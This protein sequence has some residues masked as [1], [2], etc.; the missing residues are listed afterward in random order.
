MASMQ[1]LEGFYYF[2]QVVDHG[3]F[4]RAARALGIPK[5]RLSRHVMA[6]ETR[7]NVRLVNRSTR[8]FVVTELG[9]EVYRHATAMLA[10]AD[11]ALEAVEFARAEPRGTIK[12]SSPVA[13]A[14]S[15]LAVI[16][17]DFLA[18]LPAVQVQ[19]HVSNR[20]VDVVSEGFDV[21]LRV[22][23]HPSGEDGLVMRSFRE[24][25][26][27]LV[28]S[29]AY[30]GRAGEPG[31]PAELAAYDTLDYA[32]EFDHRPWEL[33]GPGGRSARAEHTPRVVCHDFVVLRA[34][35][36]A[37]LGVARLPESVVREDLR[38]GTLKRVLPGWNTPQGIVHV[39]FPSRRGLLPAVRA[40]IDFLAERLP[41]LM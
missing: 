40:F 22:R 18:K 25:D 13:L 38:S 41:A 4:A 32:G 19:L 28:A 2:T 7:L 24:V 36:L 16:L 23:S 21:A 33:A 1:P 9:Q 20:R 6:L 39:V 3:G 10:Q 27:F 37:G 12:V 8:R 35:A 11:A 30:L 34:A 29:P 14:Q 5:S 26:E 31:D 17:P 15:A